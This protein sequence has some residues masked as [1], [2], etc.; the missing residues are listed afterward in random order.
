M[1]RKRNLLYLKILAMMLMLTILSASIPGVSARFTS[2]KSV[3]MN[4]S[5]GTWGHEVSIST[6]C[7]NWGVPGICAWPVFIHGEG[8]A[9]NCKAELTKGKATLNATTV[10]VLS[11]SLILALFDLQGASKG[12][13]DLTVTAGDGSKAVL[14]KGFQVRAGFLNSLLTPKKY[15]QLQNDSCLDQHLDPNNPRLLLISMSGSFFKPDQA[16]LL[17]SDQL[18]GGTVTNDAAG[19]ILGFNL[20]G[21]EGKYDLMLRYGEVNLLIRGAVDLSNHNQPRISS[22]D[23]PSVCME[24]GVSIDVYGA[25]LSDKM[26]LS[27]E[28]AGTRI[29]AAGVKGIDSKHIIATFDLCGAKAGTYSLEAASG[30]GKSSLYDCLVINNTPQN[31]PVKQPASNQEAVQLTISPTTATLGATVPITVSGGSFKDGVSAQL[32][33]GPS[34]ISAVS[35]QVNSSELVCT[36]D[37]AGLA[38]GT[39]DL[40]LFDSSGNAICNAGQFIVSAAG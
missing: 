12:A 33:S 3:G 35:C 18:I 34:S 21:P 8:F 27:L 15:L 19:T 28:Q 29:Q 2:S 17:A 14:Q 20:P 11:D 5:A 10:C 1:S 16:F 9:G 7:P 24:N 23:P 32:V 40:I 39:Y 25:N 30:N 13:Y 4:F 26:T 38:A 37:L 31:N 6:V 36:F 22:I